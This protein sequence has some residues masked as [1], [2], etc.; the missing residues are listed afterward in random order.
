M[1]I[2]KYH[3]HLPED[4]PKQ[5]VLLLHGVGANGQDLIGFAPL[6]AQGLPDA[7]FVSPDAPFAYDMAPPEFGGEFGNMRQWFS[8]QDRSPAAM[9]EGVE[10]AAP[11]LDAF[12]EEQLKRFKLEAQRLVL[13]G[14]S[15][16]TMMAL[17]VGLRR[18]KQFGGIIGYSGKLAGPEKL[19]ADIRSRPPLL[20]VH[21]GVDDVIPVAALGEAKSALTQN[22]LSLQT[23]ISPQLGHGIDGD[24]LRLGGVFLAESI[25]K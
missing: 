9:L 24:G 15:Q 3:E 18:E 5:L 4:E 13:V 12:I 23:H 20:L 21:G 7:A 8:L 6:L 25:G 10:R 11:L 17:H 16:G 2:E 19:K 1:T 14:F 22:D